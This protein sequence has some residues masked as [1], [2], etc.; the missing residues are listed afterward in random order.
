M[1]VLQTRIFFGTPAAAYAAVAANAS[2]TVPHGIN[3]GLVARRPNIVLPDRASPLIVEES[4]LTTLAL[5]LRNPTAVP[6]SVIMLCWYQGADPAIL[7]QG[8]T[9]ADA[10]GGAVSPLDFGA[11]LD[12]ITNDTAAFQAALTAASS[13]GV[14]TAPFVVPGGSILL[15]DTLSLPSGLHFKGAGAAATVFHWIGPADRPVFLLSG[16]QYA[17]CSDFSLVAD[18]AFLAGIRLQRGNAAEVSS[19]N[20]LENIVIDGV[21]LGI[22]GLDV[23]LN[24]IDA[25]ND[26]HQFINVQAKR[27]STACRIEGD[28]SVGHDFEACHFQGG[29]AGQYG[30]NLVGGGFH[31]HGNGG[32]VLWTLA[33]F[34]LTGHSATVLID[35][36]YSEKSARM[37]IC[38]SGNLFPVTIDNAY[39]TS[40]IGE[41]AA[42]DELIQFYSNGPLAILGSRWGLNG[43]NRKRFRYEPNSTSI[44]GGFRFDGNSVKSSEAGG[45]F[46]AQAPDPGGANLI[47]FSGTAIVPVERP[48]DNILYVP[49]W[50]Q[51]WS[52]R[53]IPVPSTWGNCQ[54]TATP[55]SLW[56]INKRDTGSWNLLPG[57][58]AAAVYQ[59]T[60]V[61]YEGYFINFT[62]AGDQR[63]ALNDTVT[64]NPALGIA[65]YISFYLNSVALNDYLMVL[66]NGSVGPYVRF[67]AAGFLQLRVNSANFATGIYNYNDGAVHRALVVYDPFDAVPARFM[68]FTDAEPAG[69]GGT[70]ASAV[71][72]N[73]VDK[74][75][76]STDNSVPSF[77]GGFRNWAFWRGRVVTL[78]NRVTC[79]QMAA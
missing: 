73:G 76:G 58:G 16:S 7:W 26:F 47:N 69:V 41:A 6:Q 34:K 9:G 70:G 17:V 54:E 60:R 57:I 11:K 3:D 20:T 13:G 65:G 22:T 43:T 25:K 40:A 27:V 39:W 59:Q 32:M 4:G 68:V 51:D 66:G 2:V 72:G 78:L 62:H 18:T 55:G 33:N 15:S 5:T 36:C 77:D 44:R 52:A 24:A 63:F 64:W 23:F 38:D 75:L 56:N 71:V 14:A 8:L 49:Q 21:N 37:L 50:P 31:W 1:A 61:G 10:D 19:R 29:A 74:G 30:I 12:G 45:Q 48:V 79:E 42:D 28:Q 35:G 46:P 53:N 67:T